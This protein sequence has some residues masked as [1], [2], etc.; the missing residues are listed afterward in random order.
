MAV[1]GESLQRRERERYS[2]K[3][4]KCQDEQE[5]NKIQAKSSQFKKGNDFGRTKLL[6]LFFFFFGES[7]TGNVCVL[8]E[9]DGWQVTM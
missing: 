3:K 8:L 7:E 5:K 6:S 2:R 4:E 1:Y 9:I